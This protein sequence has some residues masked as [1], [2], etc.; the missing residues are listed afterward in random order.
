MK[1]LEDSLFINRYLLSNLCT[2]D[3]VSS[4]G[5][6]RGGV[7]TT[8]YLSAQLYLFLLVGEYHYCCCCVSQMGPRE[9]F[10]H[11]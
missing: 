1:W 11:P 7:Y 2:G 4:Y 5:L 3:L 9:T 8:T 6:I 10:C